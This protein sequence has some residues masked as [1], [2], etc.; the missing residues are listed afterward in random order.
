MFH[1]ILLCR[2]Y[3]YQQ[4]SHF[5]SI[6]TPTQKIAQPSYRSSRYTLTSFIIAST[7]SFVSA[8]SLANK[9]IFSSSFNCSSSTSACIAISLLNLAIFSCRF[10]LCITGLLYSQILIPVSLL[11]ILFIAILLFCFLFL[12]PLPELADFPLQLCSDLFLTTV[13]TLCDTIFSLRQF[14]DLFYGFQHSSVDPVNFIPSCKQRNI[15]YY[16]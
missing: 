11:D 16:S 12:N 5:S 10:N 7:I 2:F 15:L 1:F 6:L 13:I 3:Q 14:P 8:D 4:K 9:E